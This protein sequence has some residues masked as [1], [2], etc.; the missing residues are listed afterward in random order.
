M[1]LMSTHNICFH[2]KIRKCQYCLVGKTRG[3]WATIRSPDKNSYC[4]FANAIQHS[5][6]IATATGTQPC[7]NKVKGHPSLIILINLVEL[8]IAMLHTKIQPQSF[9]STGEEGF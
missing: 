7:H 4:I 8:E 3:P 1:L 2:R 5:T 9:L 6:S